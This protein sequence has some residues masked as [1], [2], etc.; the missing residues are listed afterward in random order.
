MVKV[1]ICGI[2][3]PKTAEEVAKLGADYV[4]VVLYPKS[5]RYAPPT[6][7]REVLKALEGT[8]V[9]KVAVVVR[10]SPAFL[11]ELLEEGFDFIQLHGDESPEEVSSL[12]RERLIKAFRVKE[13]VPSAE[14][15]EGVHAFLLDAYSKEAYGGTGKGFRWELARAF[16]EKGLPFFLSG[17]LTPEKVEEAVRKVRPYGVDVSSGVER[18]KG[19]KDLSKVKE[20]IKRAKGISL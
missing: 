4:G 18:E 19:V 3:D 7:R 15:W 10:E 9:K 20:F 17:G 16:G 2:R 14:G 5:P 13:E 8:G 6:A 12:P 1:K 11:E